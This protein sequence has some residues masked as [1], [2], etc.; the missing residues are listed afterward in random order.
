MSLRWRATERGGR[1][2][3]GGANGTAEF[4]YPQGVAVDAEGNVYVADSAN[5]RVR[6]IDSA[7]KVTT[8]AGNGTWGYVDGTGGANGTAELSWPQGIAVDA[9]GNVY[10]GDDNNYRVRKID[11]A[12]NVSTFAGNGTFGYADG[13]GGPT[14]T[15][16]LTFPNGVAADAQGNVYVADIFNSRIRKI[17][18]AGNVTTLAGNGTAGYMDGTGGPTGTAEFAYPNGVAVDSQGNV[19][20][21]DSGNKRIRVISGSAGALLMCLAPLV[22][23]VSLAPDACKS[24]PGGTASPEEGTVGT[25]PVGSGPHGIAFDGANM[26]VANDDPDPDAGS[27][28]ELSPDG[29]TLGTFP[30]GRSPQ[31]IAF[32]GTNMWVTNYDSDTVTELSPDGGTV[33]TFAVGDGPT[34]SRSMARTCGS[35]IRETLRSPSCRRTAGRSPR[36]RWAAALW[37]DRVRRQ[38][39]VGYQPGIGNASTVTELSPDGGT[40]G[41]FPSANPRGGSRLTAGICGPPP[42]GIPMAASSPSCRRMAGRSVTILWAVT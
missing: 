4:G 12:G 37:C 29:G 36:L 24:A 42:V 10:V 31:Y 34:G 27:V 23:V 7:G 17:D 38:E 30:V 8:L 11:S 25:V 5:A 35:S 3:T 19:Y 15:A 16:E 33:G 28:T 6:K 40:L 14:G 22:P 18:A 39:H 32:D 41:T 2:G 20:V 26:W 13:T 1:D 21:G 9:W